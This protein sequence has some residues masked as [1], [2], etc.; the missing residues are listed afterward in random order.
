MRPE[1]QPPT[2]RKDLHHQL[3]LEVQGMIRLVGSSQWRVIRFMEIE[4]VPVRPKIPNH[5]KH[6]SLRS[7][8]DP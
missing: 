8:P 1:P 4:I 2:P 3:L 7:G 5:T 6:S